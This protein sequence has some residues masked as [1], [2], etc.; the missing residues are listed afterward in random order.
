MDDDGPE[1]RRPEVRSPDSGPVDIV[2]AVDSIAL[3]EEAAGATL[4]S[5][6]PNANVA[7]HTTREPHTTRK[8]REGDCS[9]EA[10]AH[11]TLQH[12]TTQRP[13]RS[14]LP[15]TRGNRSVLQ[16]TRSLP[17]QHASETGECVPRL[18]PLRGDA[19]SSAPGVRLLVQQ[20]G[21]NLPPGRARAFGTC[22]RVTA[23]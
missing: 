17:G 2:P 5:R 1:V 23:P 22:Q 11:T 21:R 8:A 19:L 9:V 7:V 15:L 10:Y 3:L 20:P 14:A 6:K 18:D 12:P 16:S 4:N 13:R